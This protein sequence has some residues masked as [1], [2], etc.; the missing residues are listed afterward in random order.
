MQPA[1][2]EEVV[3]AVRDDDADESTTAELNAARLLI[4]LEHGNVENAA[5]R[6]AKATWRRRRA[7]DAPARQKKPQRGMQITRRRS[8]V[9]MEVVR[10]LVPVAKARGDTRTWRRRHVRVVRIRK[11][12]VKLVRAHDWCVR[13][14]GG[15]RA[16]I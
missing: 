7:G 12:H 10:R 9:R 8:E 4:V 3:N 11:R 1:C 5:G 6:M 16:V 15:A 2:D 13:G 14:C